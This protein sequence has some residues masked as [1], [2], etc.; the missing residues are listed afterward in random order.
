MLQIKR[1][2]LGDGVTVIQ[3]EGNVDISNCFR[4]NDV[5][6][7]V[8]EAGGR[9]LVLNLEL[10]GFVDS[11]CLGA[12]L[13]GLELVHQESG[14]MVL[15]GNAFV[16]KVLTLTGLTHLLVSYPDEDS[17]VQALKSG[18]DPVGERRAPRRSPG[19]P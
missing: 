5:I 4:V 16:D 14:A 10:V 1:R 8:V 13:R 17:A 3:M 18:K 7:E 15:V 11:S 19:R 6:N 9:R 2:F 12:L